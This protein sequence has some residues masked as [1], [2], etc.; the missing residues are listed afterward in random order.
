MHIDLASRRVF[1]LASAMAL[2]VAIGYGFSLPL[3]F[4]CLLMTFILLSKPGSAIG[5]KAGILLIIIVFLALG[6][7]LLLVPVMLNYAFAGILIVALGLFHCFYRGL[8]G[9]NALIGLLVTMGLTLNTAA[10]TVSFPFALTVVEAL[11]KGTLVAIVISWVVY[12]IFP[13]DPDQGKEK[14][15]APSGLPTE[16]AQW[17]SLRS[18]LIVMPVFLVAL[19]DPSKY[20]PMIL[21]SV[22]LSQQ[23]GASDSRNAGHELIGSTLVG[24]VLA[25][26]FWFLLQILPI[27]WMFFLWMLLFFIY[28]A[29]KLYN[30]VHTQYPPSFWLNVGITL[31]ILLGPAV[32]DSSY[33]PDA[34]T[35]FLIR[36]S[37]FLVVTL[38]AWG[39]V[40]FIDRWYGHNKIGKE[41]A[42]T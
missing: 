18:L 36:L 7:S 25:L 37:L 35:A 15:A 9:G 40:Y 8:R 5:L 13:E 20:M 12:P 4:L 1:R 42:G 31:I 33:G 41:V 17:I 29:S 22:A 30:V 16:Q 11:A 28:I 23:I 27:L 26:A 10:G 39:A 38:Y 3:P 24:G 2:A 19:Y 6:I 21:K 34:M 14:S 32:Q